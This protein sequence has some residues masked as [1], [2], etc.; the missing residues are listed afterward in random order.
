MT[1][2]ELIY[3]KTIIE[4]KSISKAAEKLF[5]SQ[6]SLSKSLQDWQARESGLPLY[7]NAI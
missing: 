1:D 2:V 3:V 4:E 7:L 6:P 5:V